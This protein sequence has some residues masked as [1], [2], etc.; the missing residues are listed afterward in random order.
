MLTR[1]FIQ[2]Y[3]LVTDEKGMD[4]DKEGLRIINKHHYIQTLEP[5]EKE[6]KE[7]ENKRTQFIQN[8]ANISYDDFINQIFDELK[9]DKK[10]RS[11]FI[12]ALLNTEFDKFDRQK[13]I[14]FIKTNIE[15]YN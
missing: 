8:N 14:K 4:N 9:V 5:T 3:L 10:R 15:F 11:K 1:S 6:K 2:S 7:I 13:T 12:S